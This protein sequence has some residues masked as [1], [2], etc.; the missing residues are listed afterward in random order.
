MGLKRPHLSYRAPQR[1]FDLY[2]KST[3][4]LPVHR[5]PS[6]SAPAISYSHSCQNDRR[7][8]HG[9]DDPLQ[10]SGGVYPFSAP[11]PCKRSVINRTTG[12]AGSGPSWI[13]IN[14]DD[15]A[16]RELRLAYYAV[17]SFMDAQLG[18]VLDALEHTGLD[19][20]TVVTFIGDHG[21]QNGEKGELGQVDPPQPCAPNPNSSGEWCKST[22]FNLATRI[23]MIVV[24]PKALLGT[25]WFRGRREPTIVESIDLYPTLADLAGLPLPK[26]AFAGETLR[27]LLGGTGTRKKTWALSQWPRR[28]SCTTAHACIDGHDDPWRAKPDVAVMG[29][30]LRTDEWAY[31]WWG[32]FDWG[33]NGDPDGAASTPLFNSTVAEELY[34]HRGDTGDSQSG[35]TFE[36]DNLAY[37]PKHRS[38]I[39]GPDGLHAQLMAA[40][41]AGVVRPIE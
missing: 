27:P 20:T 8:G 5:Q 34:T 11:S 26:Q 21:Y 30:K 14:E 15:D 41:M 36:Y 2:N 7:A 19:E 3:I 40:V 17:V 4:S 38:V 9:S 18:R 16:V 25:G 24:P 28:P 33:D 6:P 12:G 35:E 37:S 29:Y 23:P 22:L 13:E 1:Y 10:V 31:I 32:R 39:T